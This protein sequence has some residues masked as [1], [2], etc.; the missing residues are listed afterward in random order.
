MADDDEITGLPSDPT[1]GPSVE[2]A[3]DAAGVAALLAEV[4]PQAGN[5]H[6]IEW[7]EPRRALI[8]AATGEH[9]LRPGGTV[10]GPAQF[11]LLDLAAYVLVLARLGRSELA[12]TSHA[13]IN[14]LTRPRVGPIV[15]TGELLKLGRSLVVTACGL[16][17]P[18]VGAELTPPVSWPDQDLGWRRLAHGEFTYS[19]SLVR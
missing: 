10:S 2:L 13:S 8:V 16:W 3:L 12:V 14:F 18:P 1:K 5:R 7:V 19:L 9:E 17:Q 4:F 15:V 11:G 6:R